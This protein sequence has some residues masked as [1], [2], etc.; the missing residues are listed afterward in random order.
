MNYENIPRY[1][2][3]QL[4]P[5]TKYQQFSQ[6]WKD[7][8]NHPSGGYVYPSIDSLLKEKIKTSNPEV[9]DINYD[10]YFIRFE[11]PLT[12]EYYPSTSDEPIYFHLTHQHNPEDTHRFTLN[13]YSAKDYILDIIG[14]DFPKVIDID[15]KDE[16]T[17]FFYN[18]YGSTGLGLTEYFRQDMSDYPIEYPTTE[19][20]YIINVYPTI[21]MNYNDDES[22]KYHGQVIDSS[23][24]ANSVVD[25]TSILTDILV[26]DVQLF[27]EEGKY[28]TNKLATFEQCVII[29][30]VRVPKEI[31]AATTHELNV[32]VNTITPE[33][34]T[35]T[36][37][38]IIASDYP[39]NRIRTIK[40]N[41]EEMINMDE[42]NEGVV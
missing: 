16:F 18:E 39:L 22:V 42:Y 36:S 20:F 28:Y 30:V 7:D 41:R 24:E 35:I 5:K 15:Q 23:Y 29:P 4:K 40:Y 26:N 10:D 12:A 33:R 9:T 21:T 8:A 31:P 34:T 3:D 14:K 27:N 32:D 13:R 38:D 25:T 17:N 6:T 37:N 1:D 11:K 19:F 2:F